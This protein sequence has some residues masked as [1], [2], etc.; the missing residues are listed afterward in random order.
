ML[1]FFPSASL[2]PVVIIIEQEVLTPPEVEAEV[3]QKQKAIA[4]RTRKSQ[5]KFK[6]HLCK[7]GTDG[8]LQDLRKH[9]NDIHPT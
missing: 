1:S 2:L 6:C 7:F 8:D 4:S 3:V 5:F 9:L